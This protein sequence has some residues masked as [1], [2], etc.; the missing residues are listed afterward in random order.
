MKKTILGLAAAMLFSTIALG[1]ATPVSS[2]P[3][4][5]PAPAAQQ[6]STHASTA[7]VHHTKAHHK[8]HK[9]HHKAA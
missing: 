7:K 8:S 4:Q 5:A 3:D 2:T 9:R 6:K 1:Q